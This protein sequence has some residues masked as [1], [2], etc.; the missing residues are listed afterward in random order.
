MNNHLSKRLF[1]HYDAKTYKG[2]D[3][4]LHTFVASALNSNKCSYLY[5]SRFTP[6]RAHMWG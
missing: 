3:V 1:E 4:Q 5:F 6:K 2:E